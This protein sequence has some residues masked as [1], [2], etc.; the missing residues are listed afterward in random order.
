MAGILRVDQANVDYIY[1]K[2]TG[3]KIYVPGHVIQAQQA[4]VT[5]TQTLSTNA[6]TVAITGLT[7]NI[8]PTST[9]SKILAM[10]TVNMGGDNNQPGLILYRNGSASSFIGDAS[11]SKSRV[12]GGMGGFSTGLIY[13]VT[14]SFLDSPSSTSALTYAMYVQT[15]NSGNIFINRSSLDSDNA[16]YNRGA[17]SIIVMELAQ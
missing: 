4:Y 17:S 14:G 6:G 9:S 3:G 12:S 7:V 13:T 1:A 10:W 15:N 5:S 2:T 11:G 8:T 16:A